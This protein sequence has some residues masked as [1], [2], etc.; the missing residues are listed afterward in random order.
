MATIVFDSHA[1][2]KRLRSAGFTE[3]QAE[4]V[5]DAS[6]DAL[7]QLVTKEDL[8]E[9]LKALEH[10][11]TIKLGGLVAAGVGIILAAMRLPQ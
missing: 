1:L 8:D 7:A 4:A 2:I 11:L 6:R 9:R 10:R 5:A 3:E